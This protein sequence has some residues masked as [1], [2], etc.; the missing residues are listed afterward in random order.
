M[1]KNSLSI[2]QNGAEY[3]IRKWKVELDLETD[4]LICPESKPNIV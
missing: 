2:T 1:Q 4:I 3:N